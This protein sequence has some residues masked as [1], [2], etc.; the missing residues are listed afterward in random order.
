[1]ITVT[2]PGWISGNPAATHAAQHLS[3][4]HAT[5]ES[6]KPSPLVVRFKTALLQ[7][8]TSTARKCDFSENVGIQ[9]M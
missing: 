3:D 2:S 9:Q 5:F 8:M 4:R 6:G 1:V 7:P